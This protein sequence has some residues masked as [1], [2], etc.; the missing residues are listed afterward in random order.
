[1]TRI[2]RRIF[3]ARW[4]S[5]SSG[6]VSLTRDWVKQ[7][8]PPLFWDDDGPLADLHMAPPL[9]FGDESGY[10]SNE[11][12]LTFCLRAS[13]YPNFDLARSGVYV[14]GA[15]NNWQ[16]G[17]GRKAWRLDAAIVQG[18]EYY[19][20]NVPK[21]LCCARGKT[22][23]K[24][25]TGN[26]EWM[27]VPSGA[28]NV[29]VDAEGH[30]NLYIHPHRTGHHQFFFKPPA[31]IENIH[32][33]GRVQ[34]R[35]E[36]YAEDA[37]MMPGEYL[38]SI[39]SEARQGA[40]VTEKG[41]F[42]RL[43]AP[44]AD[45]VRLE[46]YRSK[47]RSDA[48]F[49]E[50]VRID[51]GSWEAY[52]PGDWHGAY[53]FFY[54][55]GTPDPFSNFD[56]TMP[57]LDPFAL[58]CAGPLGPGIVIDP[59]R[60]ARP[61]VRY[62][63]PQWQD[64]VIAEAHVRDLAANAPIKL[65]ADERLGFAGLAK[66]VRHPDFPL[67]KLGVNAV[68][69]QPVQ[70]NDEPTK[71]GYHWGYMTNNFFAP[72]SHYAT[73]PWDGSQIDELRDL[74]AAFHERGIAVLLD[75]VYN[76]VGEPNF[77]QYIDKHYYFD[78]AADGKYMNWSGC[79][80][81]LDCRAPMALKLMVQ[82]LEWLVEAF[83][84][85]GFRFDLAELVGIEPLRVVE[86]RLKKLKSSIV[87]IAEPWSFRGHIAQA[88]KDTGFASWNDGYREYVRKYL[89]GEEGPQNLKYF[90]FGSLEHLSAWPAQSVNYVESHD[91]MCWMDRITENPSRSAQNPTL[92]DRR[93]TH[94]MCA[95][96]MM[97]VGIPMLS[98][99]QDFLRTKQGKNN[100]Y[101]D[102]AAN[103]LDYRRLR[104]FSGTHEYF[105][106]WIAFRRSRHG[107]LLR[108]WR[109]PNSA[110]YLRVFEA[111]KGSTAA[112]FLVN[113]DGEMGK[114]RLFF[115]VN[116]GFAPSKIDL[117]GLDL[118]AFTQVADTENFEEKGLDGAGRLP[119]EDGAVE[120]P[121]LSCALWRL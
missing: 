26:G 9:Y 71:E 50:A 40:V 83:D 6:I 27:E 1:M 117:Q 66:W 91:D 93:R 84:V 68:E 11:D 45:S 82:S 3:S 55:D 52:V 2:P 118:A 88:L 60:V 104:F 72:N 58:A 94:L 74:V 65:T 70:Q 113:A 59:A 36:G 75:V 51:M 29:M 17:F 39:D 20:L 37:L 121:P 81:T 110:T 53:Y 73:N 120:I 115:A 16:P 76:H 80:N 90:L 44:R 79:G 105:R 78:L 54:V 64:L 101:K 109:R 85:D 13:R 61:K 12:W 19:L 28:P 34:W 31:S 67:A 18:Q 22:P 48:A 98:A 116:P 69:L 99:G 57:I 103:A 41:T 95:I 46:L 14:A 62:E 42:F 30:H 15:F 106:K 86:A 38:L 7:G 87:L 97:S 47:D 100:T 32:G 114:G 107:S 77:L 21:E 102:G 96:L 4:T 8:V 63:T 5:P 43:F 10:F 23:F 119:V 56:P 92:N 25:I 112:G 24:F 89:L 33:T 49:F 108:L 111:E 35:E